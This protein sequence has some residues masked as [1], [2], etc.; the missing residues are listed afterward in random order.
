M[1]E[2]EFY[3]RVE[4]IEKIMFLLRTKP[5]LITF[6][7]APINSRKTELM[8]YLIGTFR[9]KVISTDPTMKVVRPQ[10]KLDLFAVR[11]VVKDVE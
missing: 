7:Y 10:S 8:I 11:K 3:D 5:S 2:I 1:L 4:E 9:N 6:I